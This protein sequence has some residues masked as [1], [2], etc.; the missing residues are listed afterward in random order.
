MSK[1]R[2]CKLCQANPPTVPDRNKPYR[3]GKLFDSI[4]SWCHGRRLAD[5]MRVV[6]D[7]EAKK[8]SAKP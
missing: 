6:L 7:V 4:C 1:K 5:D 8:L 2:M 3:A